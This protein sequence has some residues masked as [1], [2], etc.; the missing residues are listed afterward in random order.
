[1]REVFEHAEV[2]VRVGS[3]VAASDADG[4]PLMYSLVDTSGTFT[5]EE[6]TG[7][8]LVNDAVPLLVDDHLHRNRGGQRRAEL[9]R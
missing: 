7:Q 5:I 6:V 2:D 3:A 9:Q 4:D 1:M 8:I